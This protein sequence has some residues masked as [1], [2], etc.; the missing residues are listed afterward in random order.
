MQ[1]VQN[2]CLK[3]SENTPDDVL[4]TDWKKLATERENLNRNGYQ[5]F[6]AKKRKEKNQVSKG[7]FS[8]RRKFSRFKMAASFRNPR[9]FGSSAKGRNLSFGH[10]SSISG[11]GLS[12]SQLYLDRI[13]SGEVW[14]SGGKWRASGESTTDQGFYVLLL[15]DRRDRPRNIEGSDM[16]YGRRNMKAEFVLDNCCIMEGKCASLFNR[17]FMSDVIWR[18]ISFKIWRF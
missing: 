1:I 18:L 13:S 11:P 8:P 6:P 2:T 3:I 9:I 10:R 15:R 16:F 12:F 7:L 17:K 5:L 14:R 4:V